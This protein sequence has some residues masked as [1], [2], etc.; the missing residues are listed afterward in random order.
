M[1]PTA[2]PTK[3]PMMAVDA[4]SRLKRMATFQVIPVERRITKS[5]EG[6]EGGEECGREGREGD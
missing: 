5:P 4:E 6:R 3:K 2:T 1:V